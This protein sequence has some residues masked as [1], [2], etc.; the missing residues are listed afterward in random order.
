MEKVDKIKAFL[1]VDEFPSGSGYSPGY[2]SGYGYSSGDG[3]GSSSGD[4]SGYGYGY[5]SSDGSGDG[6]CEGSGYGYGIE[7][8]SIN[9]QPVYI[10]DGFQTLIDTVF[11]NF[12]KGKI[13]HD[14]LTTT[15]CYIAKCGNYFAHGESLKKAL[16]DAREKYEEKAPLKERIKRFNESF[17]DND[18]LI[19]GE[20]LFK[21]HH[22]LTGSCLFGRQQFC[23]ERGLSLKDRYTVNEFISIT[24]NAYGSD[25][26]KKLKASRGI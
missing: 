12:A 10:I 15:Q 18:T 14:D 3:D 19:S 8:Q 23:K 5:S 20:A 2:G 26:I 24:E 7:I 11:G 1:Q 4:G 22:I 21:W 17:P 9:G 13:L 6:S 25:A 16:A